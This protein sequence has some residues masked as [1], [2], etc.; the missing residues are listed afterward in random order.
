MENLSV[1]IP[2]YKS[3]YLEESIKS[4]IGLGVKEIIVSNF[5]T[6]KTQKLEEKYKAVK[7][8]NFNNKNNPGYFRNQGVLKSTKENLLF[9]DSDVKLTD[10]SKKFISKILGSSIEENNI[11]WGIYENSDEFS[12]TQKL[13]NEILKFRFSKK[14][15]KQKLKNPKIYCGQSS[16]V[17]LTKKTFQKIGGFN[18]YLAI[19]EDND[20]AIRASY[21]N[22][23]N[24]IH[25]DF[26][27]IHL[28]KFDAFKDYF[29]KP[30]HA[31]K[32]KIREPKIFNKSSSQI[33][34]AL[35]FQWM[36]LTPLIILGLALS[37]LNIISLNIFG[38]IVF[39][40]IAL[41]YFTIPNNIYKNLN[42]GLVTYY[43]IN[44]LIIGSFFIAG[45][46]IGLVFGMTNKTSMIFISI[47]DYLKIFYK[48][49]VRNGDPIQ[50]VNF[51]TA[52]CNLR[53]NHCFYKNTL[54]SKDPGEIDLKR[55]N[56]Y[57]KE[58]G[59]I[60]W[61]AL[62]GG[63][64]FIRSDLHEIYKIV[65]K[66]NRPKIFTIPTNGWYVEKNFQTTLRMLQLSK[67]EGSIIIQFSI[68]GEEEM[69]DSIRGNKS[70]QKVKDSIARLK[71]LQDIYKN[72]Y[73]SIITV[74]NNEN[75]NIYPEFIDK[76]IAMGT[77]QININLFRYSEYIHPPLPSKTIEKY[78]LAVERYEVYMKKNVLKKYNF[79]GAKLMRI[80]E[81]LQKDLIYDVAKHDK[82]VTPCTAGTLSYVVWE[83]GR[84]NPCE[85]LDDT[86]GN[87]NSDYIEKDLFSSKK[88]KKLR[89]RIK[90]TKCKCTYECAMSNNTLFSWPMTK[91]VISAYLT[92]RV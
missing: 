31:V 60:L 37:F 44:N 1:I 56:N 26:T 79:F 54:D 28:K 70:F 65:K 57:T 38:V 17:F 48:S 4:A 6:E 84:V 22:V 46:T 18:P 47:Y 8:L 67:G 43:F 11:Y 76:L 21:L 64:P 41:I 32:V 9:I 63:E 86:I 33:G 73:F 13:Q 82:F 80:K 36:I 75:Y 72:L 92:K 16:H 68:D 91:K 30:F 45:V 78:K 35:L 85:I 49:I 51:I 5:L 2:D 12:Y 15:N 58:F 25:N 42:Y 61:Y 34:W 71:P 10:S 77:N 89:Q 50:I 23:N 81:A 24:S 83:D 19:R 90:D 55:I 29:I 20:F 62:G 66:N 52:R 59:S 39:V 69:H 27:A 88:A 74:V 7:F 3:E 40:Y 87:V 53:C 14:T